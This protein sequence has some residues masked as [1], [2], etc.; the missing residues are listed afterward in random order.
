MQTSE[1][2][3]QIAPAIV[4]AQ[5]EWPKFVKSET[6]KV[7]TKAGADYSYSYIP[8]EAVLKGVSSQLK[9]VGLAV[10]QE[11]ASA[12]GLVGVRTVLMH[13]TG[14]WIAFDELLLPAGPD[15]QTAGS[16]MSYA[17]RYSLMSALGIA[18]EDD[19]GQAASRPK[20]SPAPAPAGTKTAEA[21]TPPADPSKVDAVAG[22]VVA[23]GESAYGEGVDTPP[24]ASPSEDHEHVWVQSPKVSKW[25]VCAVDGCLKT[26][27]REAA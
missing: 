20:A 27:K 4:A 22:D 25:D 12:P 17:R 14:Q 13:I 9:H 23:G 18:A 6:A 1:K 16:A 2:L 19:D 15:A 26:Q 8:L 3:D 10:M 7:R 21:E 24:A 11:P 5:A